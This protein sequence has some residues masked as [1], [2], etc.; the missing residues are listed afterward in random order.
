VVL[1]SGQ[2][3][4]LVLLATITHEVFPFCVH[5]LFPALLPFLN[6]SWK[7]CSVRVFSTA[8]NSALTI[9][10]VSTW[11]PFLSVLPSIR[12]TEKSKGGGEDSHVVFGK[13]FPGK[14]KKEM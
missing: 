7:S 12:E 9:S 11:Q 2:K 13:K 6:V 8:C 5:A 1:P 4:T 10:I 14:K 3:L